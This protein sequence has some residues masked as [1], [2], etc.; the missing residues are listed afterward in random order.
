[1]DKLH[2][3]I[4]PSTESELIQVVHF[5]GAFDGAVKEP[6]SEVEALVNEDKAYK[7]IFDFAELD[8]LNS[9]GIGQMVSWHNHLLKFK[10]QIALAAASKQVEEILNVLGISKMIKVAPTIEAALEMLQES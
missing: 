7:L 9:Y 4:E 2:I 8:Y 1:M 5:D 6:L 10:G 3:K